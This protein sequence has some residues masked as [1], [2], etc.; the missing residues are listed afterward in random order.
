MSSL[1][2]GLH[3]PFVLFQ[4]V[5]YAVVAPI[6]R[7][8]L[9]AF[10]KELPPPPP[11][12]ATTQVLSP[13]EEYIQKQTERF[14]KTFDDGSGT[15][16]NEN[17][18]SAFYSKPELLSVLIDADNALEQKWR[19]KILFESTPR[20]NLVM[21]Y[22]AYKQGFAYYSDQTGIPYSILNAASM[23]YTIL[24][25]CRDFFVD[26]TVLGEGRKSGIT[27]ALA[28]EGVKSAVMTE[29]MP[30]STTPAGPFA[31]FKSYNTVAN[32][33]STASDK[34]NTNAKKEEA[35][36][37]KLTNRHIALGRMSNYSFLQKPRGE[38]RKSFE[39]TLLPTKQMSYSDFKR[40]Y[41]LKPDEVEEP[42]Q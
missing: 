23:K 18:D 40:Q 20:G 19:A 38:K 16:Y 10:Q 28:D 34:M 13:T 15:N 1:L 11:P 4:F 8:F 14:L 7:F 9:R 3:P 35:V 17:V 21:F 2:F 42:R 41:T 6:Q 25:R 29:R 36:S 5:Y 12:N 32:K 24:F 37:P 30:A 39:S 26:E 22:D 27:A 31:K 33:V